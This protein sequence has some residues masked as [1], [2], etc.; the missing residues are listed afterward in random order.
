LRE[1]H[2]CDYHD[3]IWRSVHLLQSDAHVR[4]Q[5]CATFHHVLVDEFQDTNFVQYELASLLCSCHGNIFIVG[6]DQQAIYGFCR[7]GYDQQNMHRFIKDYSEGGR[8]Y[9]PSPTPF[10]RT[11]QRPP[12]TSSAVRLFRLEQNFRSSKFI[13]N[14]SNALMTNATRNS[15]ISSQAICGTDETSSLEMK[16][17]P[18]TLTS[19]PKTV[20]LTQP[21]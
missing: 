4:E 13:L 19:I 11:N 9:A 12:L 8:F 6:D 2:Y 20:T 18:K 10:P 3:L 7:A 15:E 17:C 21:L 5:F 1:C 14:C 16:V